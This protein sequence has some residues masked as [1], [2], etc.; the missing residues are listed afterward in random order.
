MKNLIKS[1]ICFFIMVLAIS[2]TANAQQDMLFDGHGKPIMIQQQYV[3]IKGNPYL[4]EDWLDAVL[5]GSNGQRYTNVKLK[6]DMVAEELLYRDAQSDRVFV[7]NLAIDSFTYVHHGINNHFIKLPDDM[8]YER[9]ANGPDYRFYKKVNKN[10]I[11]N[12]AYGAAETVKVV[13]EKTQY[14]Y[15]TQGKL[16]RLQ[17]N[18]R[19]VLRVVN[20]PKRSQLEAF[21]KEN[22]I[23]L[24]TETGVI[25]VFDFLN[26]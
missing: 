22:R 20:G 16:E 2:F 18:R 3:E 11:E 26:K 5:Y 21:I 13:V 24:S 10:I 12:Q 19:G 1:V 25:R 8:F 4:S 23:N 7:L 17:L 15:E 14:Y 9:L 6:Y